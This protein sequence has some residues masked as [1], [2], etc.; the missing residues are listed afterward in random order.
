MKKKVCILGGGGFIGSH[1]AKFIFENR[2]YEVDLVDN[3]SRGRKSL[4]S[5]LSDKT[6]IRVFDL[7]LLNS[8]NYE[9][10][11]KSYDYVFFLAAVIF[12]RRAKNNFFTGNF[13]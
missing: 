4:V 6:N 9:K 1:L 8:K 3:F 12:T 13:F 11:E 7:D 10:L 2:D 5:E